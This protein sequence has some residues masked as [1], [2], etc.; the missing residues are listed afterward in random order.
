MRVGI[1]GVGEFLQVVYTK[2]LDCIMTL[3]QF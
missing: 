1:G 3:Q 2:P